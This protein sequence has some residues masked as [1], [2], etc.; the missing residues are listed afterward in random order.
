MKNHEQIAEE[1]TFAIRSGE[2]DD[3]TNEFLLQVQWDGLQFTDLANN[4]RGLDGQFTM[5]WSEVASLRDW[6][7]F[8]LS[9]SGN[10][11]AKAR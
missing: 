4:R 5:P 8:I 3:G 6:L 10:G 9:E 11:A 1:G 7:T 2:G